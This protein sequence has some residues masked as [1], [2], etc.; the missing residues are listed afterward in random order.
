MCCVCMWFLIK[1][2]CTCFV[3]GLQSPA[4][5]R[6]I[7]WSRKLEMRTKWN[8]P[9]DTDFLG[10]MGTFSPRYSPGKDWI[11]DKIRGGEF[12][13]SHFPHNFNLSPQ[14]KSNNSSISCSNLQDHIPL[15]S[16]LLSGECMGRSP[17][18][19]TPQVSAFSHWKQHN[20]NPHVGVSPDKY[21]PLLFNLPFVA[22]SVGNG[23]F[24]EAKQ[25]GKR[26]RTQ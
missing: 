21:Q 9:F 19:V 12:S 16:L 22:S 25:R 15:K 5:F 3:L 20:L 7:C 10:K 6:R 23:G 1:T 2:W 24:E 14:A 26:T 8:W 4:G 11:A 13:L 18:W 17:H